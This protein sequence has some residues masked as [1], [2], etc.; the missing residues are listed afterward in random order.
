MELKYMQ[1]ESTL[2]E[3]KMSIEYWQSQL[4]SFLGFKDNVEIELSINPEI[5]K[6]KIPYDKALTYALSLS[7][8]MIAYNLSVLSAQQTV[9]LRKSEKG[10]NMSIGGSFG[11]NKTASAF[12]EAYSPRYIDQEGVSI[13]ISVP[14]LDWNQQKDRYRNAQSLLE[15]AQTQ[16]EQNETKFRQ[17]VY[18]QVAYF[19]MQED[20]LRIK[21]KADTIAQKGYEVSYQRY[22][23]GKVSVTDLNIADNAKDDAKK[24]YIDQLKAFWT[25]YYT[26]RQLTLFDFQ[27]NK[28]LDADFENI[29]GE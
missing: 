17:N 9:A 3:A 19:N 18:L 26:V 25:Y 29:T 27:N 8:D 11:L 12:K 1:A 6:L 4:R 14:I 24:S 13:G 2:N 16:K 15:V 22:L 20:Q 28:P 10:I 23:I 5:P 7:P 21:A